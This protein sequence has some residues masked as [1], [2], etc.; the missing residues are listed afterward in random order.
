MWVNGKEY[1]ILS[2]LSVKKTTEAH[3]NTKDNNIVLWVY[4]MHV[5]VREM[6]K[7]VRAEGRVKEL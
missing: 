7:D 1:V 3:S 6:I 2:S 4:N 5:D